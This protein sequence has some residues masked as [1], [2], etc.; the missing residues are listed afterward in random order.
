MPSTSTTYDPYD[1]Q[2]YKPVE[3]PPSAVQA[4]PPVD[5]PPAAQPG[6]VGKG[7]GGALSAVATM[8]DNIMR[9]YMRG[10]SQAEQIKA[11]KLKR[12]ADGL[13]FSY[14]NDAEKY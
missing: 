4:P 6:L 8:A 7:R 13:Q 10:K 5:V 1:P 9:G 11:M 12:K 2:P 3:L 14:N